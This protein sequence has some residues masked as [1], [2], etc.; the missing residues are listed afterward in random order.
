MD[1]QTII[2]IISSITTLLFGGGAAYLWRENKRIKNA[3]A[4]KA[5]T[6]N[7]AATNDEWQELVEQYKHDKEY[8]RAEIEKQNAKIVELYNN[9]SA[10]AEERRITSLKNQELCFWK[11]TVTGC[12]KRQ[13]PREIDGK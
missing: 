9:L 2:S 12:I 13:P 11:C 8:Y 6:E 7:V 1:I 4:E 3:E 10:C 5:E